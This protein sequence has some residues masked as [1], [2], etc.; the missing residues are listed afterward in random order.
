MNALLAE[1]WY[2]EEPSRTEGTARIEEIRGDVGEGLLVRLDRT[3]FYPEGGGQPCDSGEIE[4][5]RVVDVQEIEGFVWHRLDD[6]SGR[7]AGFRAGDVV[8]LRI[9]GWRRRDHT[10]QHTGQHL[11]SAVLEQEHGIHTLSFHLGTTYST[12][13]ISAPAFDEELAGTVAAEVEAMIRTPVPVIVHYCPPEDVNSFRLRKKPPVDESVI[14]IVEIGGYDWSPCGGT[15]LV[16]TGD[17]RL[18]ELLSWERYKGNTRLYFV[19]GDRAV[20]MLHAIHDTAQ[21]AAAAFGT[22]LAD[23]GERAAS[24]AARIAEQDRRIRRLVQERA[25]MEASMMHAAQPEGVLVFDQADRSSEEAAETAKAAAALG[26]V[27]LVQ[28]RSEHA[29]IV[30]QPQQAAPSAQLGV[31]L[32]PVLASCNGKGGGGPAFFR[33]SFSSDEDMTAFIQHALTL[34]DSGSSQH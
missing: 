29:V 24:I 10:Q 17:L 7:C 15:H 27:A 2:Y 34:L 28:C 5:C 31:L 9:D 22:G 23:L 13:D 25:V 1:R 26:R 33:A 14:R 19:A 30:Q 21:K 16:S 12:I 8:Q 20:A 4:G 3:L 6:D 18:L 32:K 11:L